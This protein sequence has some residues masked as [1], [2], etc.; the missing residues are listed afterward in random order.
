MFRVRPDALRT[1]S[2]A[3]T[4]VADVSKALDA[5]RG[6]ITGQLSRSGSEP[7]SRSTEAFLDAWGL[8]LRGVSERVSRLGGTLHQAS[9]EY[10]VAEHRLR[11]HL[12]SGADG[13]PA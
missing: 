2:R 6:E 7:L 12:G 1:S 13:G 10:E 8:G 3:L 5:S 9:S 4:D 11:G